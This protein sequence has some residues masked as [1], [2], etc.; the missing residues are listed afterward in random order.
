M[1]IQGGNK[2]VSNLWKLCM[3]PIHTY[4]D[5]TEYQNKFSI[6]PDHFTYKG[7]SKSDVS[8]LR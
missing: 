5:R 2:T 4:K 6:F 1:L 7:M 8:V 3:L